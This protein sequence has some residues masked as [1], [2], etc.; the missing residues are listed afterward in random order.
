MSALCSS[1]TRKFSVKKLRCEKDNL[2][3]LSKT[4]RRVS[5]YDPAMPGLHIFFL[6]LWRRNEISA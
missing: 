3:L 1:R 6:R 2:N 4:I 5:E